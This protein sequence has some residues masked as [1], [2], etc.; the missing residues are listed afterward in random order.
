MKDYLVKSIAHFLDA[1]IFAKILITAILVGLVWLLWPLFQLGAQIAFSIV[2]MM[3]GLLI[4]AVGIVVLFV[5]V[6]MIW[7]KL[8]PHLGA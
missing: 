2:A 1:N 6:V 4:W 8:M 7:T 3:L 5:A